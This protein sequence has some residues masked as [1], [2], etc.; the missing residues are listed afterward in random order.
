[1]AR[2]ARGHG[3]AATHAAEKPHR[4]RAGLETAHRA[5][6][7][8]QARRDARL[9]DWV[10]GKTSRYAKCPA[11]ANLMRDKATE[12]DLQNERLARLLV[13]LEPAMPARGRDA[14]TP[15]TQRIGEL[16]LLALMLP[17]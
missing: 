15:A 7:E 13:R 6:S 2:L 17:E 14:D 12:R 9:H 4:G 1:M 5:L 8:D 10:A 11:A 3:A 16:D